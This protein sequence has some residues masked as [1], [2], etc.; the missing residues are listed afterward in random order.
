MAE[1]SGSRQAL[2]YVEEAT[3]GVT[4]ATPEF[5]HFRHNSN[6]LNLTKD[7]FQSEELRSDRQIADFRHGARQAGGDV[8]SEFS[9][10]SHDA[11]LAAALCGE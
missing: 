7:A 5:R 9:A 10:E 3:Y 8:V 1:A 2:K 4:P 6:T 11:M